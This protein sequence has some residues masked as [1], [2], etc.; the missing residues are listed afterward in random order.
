[1]TRLSEPKEGQSRT[2]WSLGLP[3]ILKSSGQTLRDILFPALLNTRVLT[4]DQLKRAFVEFDHSYAESKVGTYITLVSSQLGMAKND[5]LRQVVSY[6]YLRH[7]WEK[8]NFSIRQ[9]YR[10]L[11]KEVVG[12]LK[13][14]RGSA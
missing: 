11:V 4:R 1:M 6:D 2:T 9:E 13:G 5:F 12:D 8:D 10:D 7:K 14:S 3:R